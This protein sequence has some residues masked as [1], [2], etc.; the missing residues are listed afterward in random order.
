[1]RGLA[2]L[3]TTTGLVTIEKKFLADFLESP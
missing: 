3:P 1:V 2:S